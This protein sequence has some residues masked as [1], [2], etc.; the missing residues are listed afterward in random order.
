M[1]YVCECAR[2][3]DFLL[4]GCARLLHLLCNVLY[5]HVLIVGS[6]ICVYVLM[7][8]SVLMCVCV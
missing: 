4:L 7:D 1:T 2:V 5:V 8:T 3:C 6:C